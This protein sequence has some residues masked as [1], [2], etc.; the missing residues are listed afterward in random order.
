MIDGNHIGKH[1]TE[2][3]AQDDPE[4]EN[5]SRDHSMPKQ[6]HFKTEKMRD[7]FN[8]NFSKGLGVLLDSQ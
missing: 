6:R 3:V 2:T 8:R 7:H 5:I 4:K 1:A